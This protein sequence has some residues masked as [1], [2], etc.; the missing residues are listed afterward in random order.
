MKKPTVLSPLIIILISI[1]PSFL[2]TLCSFSGDPDPYPFEYKRSGRGETAII[3]IPGFASAAAVWDETRA[4]FE[5][6][7]T[8]YTLTMAGFAGVKPQPNASFRNW[9]AGI[10][11]FIKE[12][13]L[14][15]PIIVGH[16][17]GGAL[18]MALAADYPTLVGKI[19]VVDA[20][21]CLSALTNPSFRAAANPDC[22]PFIDQMT[23][24]SDAQFYQMQKMTM[25]SMTAD[26]TAQTLAVSWSMQSDRNTLGSMFC[27]FLNTD[28]RDNIRTVECPALILLEPSFRQ[29]SAAIEQQ[30]A[31]LKT[32]R[33]QYA[34]RGL[35]FI[36]YDDKEWYFSQL[37]QFI[38]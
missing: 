33:L 27:D 23:A 32:A 20:L 12:N 16:S 22:A 1:L 5:K 19:I 21:P 34:N 11:R 2:I 8:C 30:Y 17:M 26:T 6:R 31:N 28:L 9:V 13:N 18:A 10:A 35:H 36:M 7:Y 38:G 14:E 25:K 29:V 3:F 4:R 24:T 15:K 37:E